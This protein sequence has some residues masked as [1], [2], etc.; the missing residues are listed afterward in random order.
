MLTYA[1]RKSILSHKKKIS[2][3]IF[4]WIVKTY[5]ISR[6]IANKKGKQKVNKNNRKLKY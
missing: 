1:L 3:H 2:Y 5:D 6:S 4:I